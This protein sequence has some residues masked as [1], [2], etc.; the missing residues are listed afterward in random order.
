[1]ETKPI[2]DPC[3]GS[4]MFYMD[5]KDDRVD[6]CDIRRVNT[7]LC[8]GRTLII[9][10]DYI[11]DVT[12]LPQDD[13]SYYLVVF[14]PPTFKHYRR[15]LMDGEKIWKTTAGLANIYEKSIY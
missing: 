1:M 3:C 13:E 11:T 14:D 9:E 8:D 6:F 4:K 5:K 15:N 2:L 10:P 7:T 12:Q